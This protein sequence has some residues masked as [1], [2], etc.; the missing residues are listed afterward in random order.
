MVSSTSPYRVIAEDGLPALKTFLDE[1]VCQV[2]V[3][4]YI[5]D[6]PIAFMHAYEGKKDREIA[7]FFAALMAWGR[8]DIVMAKVEQL[9]TRMEHR[10][11]ELILNYSDAD[12]RRFTGFVHRTW[13]GFDIDLLC[14]TLHHIYQKFGDFEGFWQHLYQQAS[15]E[16]VPFMR[17]F[18]TRFFEVIGEAPGRTRRHIG[19]GLKNSSCKRLW[20]YLRWSI[21]TSSCVDLGIM[22]FIP[23]SELMIP[24][25]VHVARYARK[26]GLLERTYNDWLAVEELTTVLKKLDPQ[27]PAKYDYAL[28]GLGVRKLGVPEAFILNPLVEP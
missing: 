28:F 6:D 15:Q 9:L 25:D 20:L 1:V 22:H 12:S 7:G 16:N 18:H 3:P 23:P 27:D 21:R 19:D 5:E 4:T 14:R 10:P 26:L 11:A 2:E 17:L 13:N 8:R 24:L